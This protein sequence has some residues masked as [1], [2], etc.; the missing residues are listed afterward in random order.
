MQPAV[1]W[2]N[3]SVHDISRKIDQVSDWQR[4]AALGDCLQAGDLCWKGRFGPESLA[5]SLT[6]FVDANE[7]SVAI[8][9]EDAPGSWRL[10][11][12][13]G[14]EHDPAF[15]DAVARKVAALPAGE[16]YAIDG[17]EGPSSLRR[18][19]ARVGFELGDNAYANLWKPLSEADQWMS[20]ACV[21]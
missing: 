21:A 16:K 17:P 5:V 12:R 13:P 18:E 14:Q 11:H 20:Q 3:V 2:K 6:E 15:G 7:C 19:L 8:L 4:A 10:A 9:L 1:Q